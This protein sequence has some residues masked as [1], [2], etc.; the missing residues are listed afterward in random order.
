LEIYDAL[1]NY[2]NERKKE[3]FGCVSKQCHAAVV[4]V[5][6]GGG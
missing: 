6:G 2:P 5:G 1:H 3:M 4:V